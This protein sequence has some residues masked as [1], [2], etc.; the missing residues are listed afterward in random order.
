[1]IAFV[2]AQ[3]LVR[4]LKEETVAA[5]KK[6]A[7]EH[8]RSAEAE[9]RAILEAALKQK[10]EDFWERADQMRKELEESGRSFTDS[11]EL[12]RQARDER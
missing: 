4:D 5:L 2:M 11:T 10:K 7:K 1:M 12:I 6:R 3:L 9:H 8:G